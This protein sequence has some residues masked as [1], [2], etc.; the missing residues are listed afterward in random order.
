MEPLAGVNDNPAGGAILLPLMV[1]SSP[2]ETP[3][4]MP[5][6][7]FVITRLL[8]GFGTVTRS[9]T[10]TVIAVLLLPGVMV[11]VPLY[12][13]APAGRLAVL[14]LTVRVVAVPPEAVVVPDVGVT[15]S[16]FPPAEVVA[17]A[18]NGIA[19]PLLVR[20]SVWFAGAVAPVAC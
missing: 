5:E 16:Q 19:A 3:R 8:G 20:L 12:V 14:T 7:V 9:V 11:I 10:G 4:A 2:G 6:A 13:F 17:A 18:V 1:M 15:L